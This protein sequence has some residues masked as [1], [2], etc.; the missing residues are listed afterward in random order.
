MNFSGDGEIDSLDMPMVGPG[1]MAFGLRILT[2][3]SCK[4]MAESF[5]S[6]RLNL[7]TLFLGETQGL[8]RSKRGVSFNFSSVYI[9]DIVYSSYFITTSESL[10]MQFRGNLLLFINLNSQRLTFR[11]VFL[12]TSFEFKIN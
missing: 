1:E 3:E 2:P 8:M 12:S 4:L 7:I 10:L 6:A 9:Y 5:S 11:P